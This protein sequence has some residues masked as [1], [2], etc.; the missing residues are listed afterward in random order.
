MHYTAD[1]VVPAGCSKVNVS[2][3]AKGS[4]DFAG[5]T[6][7]VGTPLQVHALHV[8]AVEVYFMEGEPGCRPWIRSALLAVV[9]VAAVICSCGEMRSLAISALRMGDT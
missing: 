6:W 7:H 3:A 1:T 4:Q 2:A 5:F 9:A 8:Q